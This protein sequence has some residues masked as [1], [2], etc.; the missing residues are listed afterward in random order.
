MRRILRKVREPTLWVAHTQHF[1]SPI[2][3]RDSSAPQ[4]PLGMT[5]LPIGT[6]RECSQGWKPVPRSKAKNPI[7]WARFSRKGIAFSGIRL[8]IIT[9]RRSTSLRVPGAARWLKHFQPGAKPRTR[10]RQFGR[11]AHGHRQQRPAVAAFGELLGGMDIARSQVGFGLGIVDQDLN[12]DRF[13]F[14]EDLE[15]AFGVAVRP[16]TGRIETNFWKPPP[17]PESSSTLRIRSTASE[18]IRPLSRSSRSDKGRPDRQ[19]GC[20]DRGRGPCRRR[21]RVAAGIRNQA[22]DDRAQKMS[23]VA[24]ILGAYG[25]A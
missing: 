7:P 23:K 9:R 18:M 11:A 5:D 16:E 4:T 17:S 20:K 24:I 19:P 14:S 1:I 10:F 15:G 22:L 6:V 25:I 8:G 12:L 3:S 13:F 2:V 21:N